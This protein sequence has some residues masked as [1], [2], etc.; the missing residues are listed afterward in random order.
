MVLPAGDAVMQGN[1]LI[2]MPSTTFSDYR[3][4][5]HHAFQ[6]GHPQEAVSAGCLPAPSASH[7]HAAERRHMRHMLADEHSCESADEVYCWMACRSMENITGC[8]TEDVLCLNLQ[9]FETWEDGVHCK[10]CGLICPS[11]VP[12]TPEPTVGANADSAASTVS[13]GLSAVL[14]LAAFVH[15]L[16][17]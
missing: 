8:T 14:V 16:M 1:G 4:Q 17:Y 7:A 15:R 5:A 11:D 3:S 9:T 6:S 13:L 10:D 12:G 2:G